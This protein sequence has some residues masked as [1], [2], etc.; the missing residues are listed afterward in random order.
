MSG[1]ELQKGLKCRM[2]KL[3]RVINKNIKCFIPARFHVEFKLKIVVKFNTH[4]KSQIEE[5]CIILNDLPIPTRP[6]RK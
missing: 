1:F 4:V 5:Y 6:S 2:K 3:Q